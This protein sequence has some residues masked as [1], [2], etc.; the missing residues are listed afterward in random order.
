VKD[1]ESDRLWHFLDGASATASA[2]ELLQEA[3]GTTRNGA[4][5]HQFVVTPSC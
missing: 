5:A 1:V 4:D 3:L 2:F